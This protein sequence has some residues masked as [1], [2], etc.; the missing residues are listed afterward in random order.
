MITTAL[1]AEARRLCSV[2]GLSQEVF[3]DGLLEAAVG[4]RGKA[5]GLQPEAFLSRLRSDTIEQRKLVEELLVRESW[6]WRDVRP[7]EW[8]SGWLR[9]EGWPARGALRV[10]SAPCANGEEA[11]SI[12]LAALHIGVKA[13]AIHVDALDLSLRGLKLARAGRYRSRALRSLPEEL[14]ATYFAEL[15]DGT[16]QLDPRCVSGVRFERANLAETGAVA[17]G[18]PYDVIF[19]RNLLIYLDTST[20]GRLLA[21]ITA[22]LTPGGAL[23]LGHAE[24]ALVSDLPLTAVPDG[25]SFAFLR[26][27]AT[28]AQRPLRPV[29]VTAAGKRLR[30][31]VQSPRPQAEVTGPVAPQGT[32]ASEAR[33]LADAGRYREAMEVAESLRLREPGVADH[34][35]LVGLLHSALG[36]AGAARRAYQRALYLDPSHGPSREQLSLLLD[37]SGEAE[38]AARLRRRLPNREGAI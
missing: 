29:S 35:Y 33:A 37:S 17:R 20:R 30:P 18:A 16:F 21:E 32:A 1:L 5:L 9:E 2:A 12:L 4:R 13:S 8:F 27:R 14:R 15:P 3:T 6:F 7:F 26:R 25:S 36:D 19:C 34:E 22:S 38:R 10:L 31:S 23:V 11:Y 28:E 24:A